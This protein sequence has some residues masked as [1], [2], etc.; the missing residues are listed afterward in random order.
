ML[1]ATPIP[2]H[3]S[4]E[5][6]PVDEAQDIE[7]AAQALQAILR[8]SES[9][10]KS[11]Q[12]NGDAESIG[13]IHVKSHGCA[14]AEFRVLPNLP[15]DLAQ[16]LFA[17]DRTYEAVVRFS[18]SSPF[19]QSDVIPDGRGMA[20]KVF[21]VEGNR[22]E[23]E[24]NG[25]PTQ[26][27]ILVNHPVFFAPNVKELLRV[28]QMLAAARD[29]NFTAAGEVFTRGDWNPLRW[30]WRE[31]VTAL[32]IASHAPMNPASMTYY[33]MSPFRFGRYVAR[34]R[35]RPAGELARDLIDLVTR[36]ASNPNA[37]RLMLEE[38]L[39]S[40]QVL[41]E[42]QVQLR[43]S[44]AS[45]PIEDATVEWP[46]TESPYRT[47]GLILMPRQEINTPQQ[48]AICE[49]LSFDVWHAL[50]EHRPLVAVG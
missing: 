41:F 46:E 19:P 34:F 44:D 23:S 10:P 29:R 48:Q 21:E 50:E 7:R 1:R 30:H 45:M 17:Q 14:T 3:P 42:F 35:A 9:P 2:Y 16:G 33:S 22:L 49:Q 38:T 25:A 43:T 37:M 4:V 8:P 5:V 11:S 24:D 20:I 15:E 40:Q 18:N 12:Q 13:D 6:V 27:F 47:V 32:R 39:R 36:L 26:D 31:A 28:E